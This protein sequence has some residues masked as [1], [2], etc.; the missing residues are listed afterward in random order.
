MCR[1]LSRSGGRQARRRR[2][3]S[4]PAIPLQI[5]GSSGFSVGDFSPHPG[6]GRVSLP[7]RDTGLPSHR[8]R[9]RGGTLR[10]SRQSSGSQGRGADELPPLRPG[11][12]DRGQPWPGWAFPRA[13]AGGPRNRPALPR[14]GARGCVA[15]VRLTRDAEARMLQGHRLAPFRT[16]R[17]WPCSRVH[18]LSTAMCRSWVPTEKPEDPLLILMLSSFAANDQAGDAA[19]PRGVLPI[20]EI[21]SPTLIARGAAWG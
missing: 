11:K 1:R 5:L 13:F 21:G 14:L 18:G 10:A 7:A 3:S 12:A 4:R 2:A 19:R 8:P 6:S 20:G 16:R 17:K 15:S 9:R